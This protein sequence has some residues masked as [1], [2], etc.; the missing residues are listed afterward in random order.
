[1]NKQFENALS[2][3]EKSTDLSLKSGSRAI[4]AIKKFH[5]A[6]QTGNV[7]DI[8]K[9]KDEAILAIDKLKADFYDAQSSWDFDTDAYFSDH[10]Y[11]D[12]L[13]ACASEEEFK[14]HELDGKLFCYPLLIKPQLADQSVKI[15]KSRE[16]RL[17][18]SFL[19]THLKKLQENPVRFKAEAFLQAVFDAFE[20]AIRKY[21]SVKDC[22]GKTVSI[23]EIYDLL[24]L[25]PGSSKEYTI[26][27]F[28]RD[29]YLLD[30]NHQT[31]TR[32][33]YQLKFDASS[34]SRL[35]SRC[36]TVVTKDGHEKK[37]YV[38]SFRAV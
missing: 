11:I 6:V 33:G 35:P 13:L 32:D 9:Y 22:Q 31:T 10:S 16:R 27:E 37:Y 21:G 19:I 29:I 20:I 5:K 8:R 17:R 30:Q 26:Q 36:L 14:I 2:K 15:D 23:V 7:R 24:T 28:A 4:G 18:P 3:T 1:M 12:E 25:L 38:I 34:G